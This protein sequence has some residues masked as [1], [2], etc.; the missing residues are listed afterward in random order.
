[1][2]FPRVSI[3]WIPIFTSLP[4]CVQCLVTFLFRHH[5]IST[6]KDFPCL[7][8]HQNLSAVPHQRH[9]RITYQSLFVLDYSLLSCD[10]CSIVA[11]PLLWQNSVDPLRSLFSV[12]ILYYHR[13]SNLLVSRPTLHVTWLSIFAVL[14]F[15][16]DCRGENELFQR[17][18]WYFDVLKDQDHIL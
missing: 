7:Q 18:T 15:H 13:T 9:L 8:N 5:K 16:T 17:N 3:V 4:Q 1:M 14:H 11:L 10:C 2:A 6:G 12:S